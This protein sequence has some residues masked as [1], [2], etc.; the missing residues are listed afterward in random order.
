MEEQPLPRWLRATELAARQYGT[1]TVEQLAAMG[2]RRASIE[3]AVYNGRLRRLHHG[4]YAIGH[5]DLPLHGRCLAAVS[6]CG[7]GAVLSHYS[8]AWLWG[9]ISTQPTPVHVTTPIPRKPRPLVIIHHSRTLTEE[10]RGMEEEIPVTSIPRTLLDLAPLVRFSQLRRALKRSEE[11]KL[12]DLPAVL[13]VLDRNKGHRGNKPLRR[14][15]ALYEPPRFTRSQT[16]DYFVALVES[17]GLP[18]PATNW[19]EAGHE[20]D[21]YW[22]ELRFGVEIDTFATHGTHQSFEDDRVRREDLKLAGIEMTQVTDKRLEREPDRVVD[23]V[24]RLLEQRRRH[25][26]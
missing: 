11:L 16:E 15:L 7:P 22:P 9:L 18:R 20:I 2:I 4:V 25:L 24:A 26:A 19:V 23:R 17:A 1:V 8:A 5:T 10:D 3:K 13:S 14:A 6:A 12:F 21:V